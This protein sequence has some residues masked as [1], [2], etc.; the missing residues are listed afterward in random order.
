M[1]VTFSLSLFLQ[2]EL[3]KF[4]AQLLPKHKDT[5]IWIFQTLK[6]GG[7]GDICCFFVEKPILVKTNFNYKICLSSWLLFSL[8]PDPNP[9]N[10]DSWVNVSKIIS[11]FRILRL[12]FVESQPQNTE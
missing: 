6:G 12:T 2:F 8:R 3:G 10:I 4:L 7:G 1:T 5:D 9:N 11:E